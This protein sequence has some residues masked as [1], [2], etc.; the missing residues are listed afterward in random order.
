MHTEHLRNLHPGWVVGGW[1]L[2]LAVT[3]V[4]FMVGVGLGL[5][6][7]ERAGTGVVVPATVMLGF[8]AGGLFVGL[9]WADA[10]IL[11]GAAITFL[12]VL[13]WFVGNLLVPGYA[14]G[15]QLGLDRPGFI[16]GM[17]VLQLVATVA[18][19]W[20]GRRLVLRG[21]V[22]PEPPASP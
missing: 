6:G 18:G 5:I 7:P 8:Y 12:S 2:A 3:S 22:P 1:L 10:P 21:S 19:G 11:H 16:L 15:E 14:A 4:V 13:V 17:V 9:R 20:T